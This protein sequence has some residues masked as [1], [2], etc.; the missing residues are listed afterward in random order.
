MAKEEELRISDEAAMVLARRM[1]R[2]VPD[3]ERLQTDK[4]GRAWVFRGRWVE[5]IVLCRHVVLTKPLPEMVQGWQQAPEHEYEVVVQ[6]LG[7]DL[8]LPANGESQP[9]ASESTAGDRVMYSYVVPELDLLALQQGSLPAGATRNVDMLGQA[10]PVPAPSPGG[11]SAGAGAAPPQPM[12][13]DVR[14]MRAAM[15]LAYAM[16]RARLGLALAGLEMEGSVVD[17]GESGPGG[18]VL[19][20]DDEDEAVFEGEGP[21][22]GVLG[23]REAVDWT[24]SELMAAGADDGMG[25]LHPLGFSPFEDADAN[26]LASEAGGLEKGSQ[27]KDGSPTTG[28]T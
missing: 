2:D 3:E 1:R 6:V 15:L 25:R 11:G 24:R 19:R 17:P 10:A 9:G 12:P 14:G 22:P 16:Y 26:G 4:K 27:G 21:W 5:D 8:G 28:A 20:G 23:H 13:E 18:I 7:I